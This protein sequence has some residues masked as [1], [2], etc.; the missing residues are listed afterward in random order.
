MNFL[1]A[2]RFI[3]TTDAS[4]RWGNRARRTANG[5]G[6]GHVPM[7]WTRP[8]CLYFLRKWILETDGQ[9]P[10]TDYNELTKGQNLPTATSLYEHF[11]WIREAWVR[12]AAPESRMKYAQEP[13]WS[14][15]EDDFL[16]EHAGEIS[17]LRAAK[18]LG[19][20]EGAVKRRCYK[21]GIFFRQQEGFL[22]AQ[23]VA[24]QLRVQVHRV[25]DLIDRELLP[26]TKPR[27]ARNRWKIDPLKVTPEL[28][29]ILRKPNVKGRDRTYTHEQINTMIAMR[30]EGATFKMIS[31]AIGHPWVGLHYRYNMALDRQPRWR[32]IWYV[33]KEFA[34]QHSLY[35][36]LEV[37]KARGNIIDYSTAARAVR[38]KPNKMRLDGG[39]ITI[40]T[41]W[42]RRVRPGTEA[43]R[44]IPKE[45]EST[46]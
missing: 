27:H 5:A 7:L 37:L 1:D 18:R 17:R 13:D 21:L 4:D 11:G 25:Y 12:A 10:I 15:A 20:S 46:K 40:V 26:A 31:E 32:A 44:V 28:V 14:A 41:H 34:G 3:E 43:G 24:D 19:R 36:V 42:S 35:D 23:Q 39:V 38:S 29:E 16:R 6:G 8:V 45:M 9:L 33:V 30:E 2:I 22:S